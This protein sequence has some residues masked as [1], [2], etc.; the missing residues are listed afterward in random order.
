MLTKIGKTL[1]GLKDGAI[2]APIRLVV[3]L[4]YGFTEAGLPDAARRTT[5]EAAKIAEEFGAVLAYCN[6]NY[7]GPGLEEKEDA[8]KK[9]IL[10]NFYLNRVIVADPCQN[11]VSEARNIKKAF[12]RAKVTTPSVIMVV[13]DWPHARST[14]LIWNKVFLS[15]LIRTRSV[16]GEWDKTH[17]VPLQR[18]LPKWLAANILR[19]GAL[20]VL[21]TD[22]VAKKQYTQ[23]N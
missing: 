16:E 5:L 7:L 12:Q 13:C 8:A 6:V 18:S 23:K 4:G 9:V 20:L 21:G 15:S 14:R 17:L 3:P 2:E 1:Y 19:H 22:W 11:S 10:K